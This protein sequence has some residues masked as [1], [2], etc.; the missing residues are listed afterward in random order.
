MY[1]LKISEHLNNSKLGIKN[2]T[3]LQPL[4]YDFRPAAKGLKKEKIESSRWDL[5]QTSDFLFQVQN[6]T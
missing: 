3:S 4:G 5:I 1:F 2:D 6:L